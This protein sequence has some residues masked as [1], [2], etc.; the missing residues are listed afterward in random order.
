MKSTLIEAAQ[1][2]SKTKSQF[3][4]YHESLRFKRGYKRATVA[5]AHKMMRAVY[6]MM[7][8]DQPY[9]D[10]GVDYEKMMVDRNAPRWKRKL[11]EFGHLD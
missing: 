6:T 8:T 11:K 2:A 5:V 3:K 1:A 7:R 4:S 9:R 10:P